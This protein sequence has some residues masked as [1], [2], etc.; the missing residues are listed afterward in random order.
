ME[1]QSGEASGYTSRMSTVEVETEIDENEV[2]LLE[3][4]EISKDEDIPVS[5]KNALILNEVIVA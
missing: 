2:L 5:Y 4:D 1:I 3:A